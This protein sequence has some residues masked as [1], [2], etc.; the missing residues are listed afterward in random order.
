MPSKGQARDDILDTIKAAWTA[1]GAVTETKAL[2]YQNVDGDPDETA[3][4]TKD[5]PLIYGRVTVRHNQGQKR[6]LPGE[7]GGVS[8]AQQVEHT[9]IVIVQ[10]F[11]PAGEGL[12]V[13]DSMD[14]I[15]KNACL[16]VRTANGV[17]FE[18]ESYEEVGVAGAWFQTNVSVPFKY[19][20]IKL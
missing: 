3:T 15:I 17:V 6:T 12:S 8:N 19:D 4:G 16:G 11:A 13:N 18:A 1:V 2:L 10:N 14:E 20:E 5:D 7:T 9:G